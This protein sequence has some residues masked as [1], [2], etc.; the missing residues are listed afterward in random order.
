V[1]TVNRAQFTSI[2]DDDNYKS[3]I[4][5]ADSYQREVYEKEGYE[6]RLLSRT[7]EDAGTVTSVLIPWNTCGM[8]QST[9]LGVPTLT[10]LPYCFFNLIS[11]F[12]SIIVAATGWKIRR[13]KVKSEE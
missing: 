1:P 13:I 11:P 12:M 8:T 4:Q 10:Y 3:A 7:T 6:G 2:F 5:Y 9:V